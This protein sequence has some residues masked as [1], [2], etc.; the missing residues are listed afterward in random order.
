MYSSIKTYMKA[1]ILSLSKDLVHVGRHAAS[2]RIVPERNGPIAVTDTPGNILW[3]FS[4]K[5]SG[6]YITEL[7]TKATFRN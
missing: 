3:H 5:Y 4:G 6:F 1:T 7:Q 2:G